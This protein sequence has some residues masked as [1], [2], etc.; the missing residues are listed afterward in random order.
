MT[1]EVKTQIENNNIY[2][3]GHH[4]K[5]ECIQSGRILSTKAWLTSSDS[6]IP[7]SCCHGLQK[8]L[9]MRT[10]NVALV[11]RF[12][13]FLPILLLWTQVW[14]FTTYVY[15]WP[16]PDDHK[17][18]IDRQHSIKSVEDIHKLTSTIEASKICEGVGVDYE[19][20]SAAIID[21]NADITA[22]GS[23]HST[24]VVCHS[25]PQMPTPK[26]SEA[27]VF[28]RSIYCLVIMEASDELCNPCSKASKQLKKTTKKRT[29]V[30]PAKN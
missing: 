7:L 15:N 17:I 29:K 13:Q 9:R 26:Q 18:Y 22:F 12:M 6:L 16:I 3:C 2:V 24:T 30:S 27:T 4:F 14:K 21:P 19:S 25:V 5:A 23:I 20:R 11:T 28:F 10:L 8:L 1:P